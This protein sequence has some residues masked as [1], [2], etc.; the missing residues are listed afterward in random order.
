MLAWFSRLLVVGA[1]ALTAWGLWH[2]F[3][4]SRTDAVL[5]VDWPQFVAGDVHVGE[6]EVVLRVANPGR[7]TQ[8]IVGMMKGCGVNG[9]SGPKTDQPIDVP[10]GATVNWPFLLDVRQAGDFEIPVKLY[11]ED[12]GT[13]EM[14]HTLRGT[15]IGRGRQQ[16]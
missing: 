14:E 10:P 6:N 15:A 4:A 8:R 16:Q 11:V 1:T 5:L 2:F 3:S 7:K 9:C 13:R 12:C